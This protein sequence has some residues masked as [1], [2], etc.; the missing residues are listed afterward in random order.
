[1]NSIQGNVTGI[2]KLT[3]RDNY[4]DWKFA[5]KSYLELDD[6]WDAV[7]GTEEDAKKLVKAKSK[8]NLSLDPTLYVHVEECETAKEAWDN[9][10][11]VFNDSGLTRRIS[12]LKTLITT[13]L[14]KCEC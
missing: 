12:L 8:I 11:A 7:L 13:R 3:G 2:Q 9:L 6:L 5:M 14:E 10:A 4:R 1:M